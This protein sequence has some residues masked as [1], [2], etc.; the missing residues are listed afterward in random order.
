M[1]IMLVYRLG[2]V[3]RGAVPQLTCCDCQLEDASLATV[4]LFCPDAASTT[5]R[6]R[7]FLE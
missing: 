5:T 3:Q 4:V 2:L 7:L 6:V 1:A